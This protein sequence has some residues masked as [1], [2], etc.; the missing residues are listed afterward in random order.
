MNQSELV[1]AG[2]DVEDF[3]N[4]IMQNTALVKI[5]VK[6]FL[7]DK[8]FEGLEMAIKS[9]D[10]RS[11]ESCCHTLKGM[12]G[13]M[14]LKELFPLFQEQLAFFRQGEY[15]KAAE[16]M[17]QIRALYRNAIQHMQIWLSEEA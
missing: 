3:L 10:M 4:R 8:N 15:E 9:G 1:K 17:P 13:N 12:S 2:M 5:F 7:E 11:A 14:S 6:K 16:M